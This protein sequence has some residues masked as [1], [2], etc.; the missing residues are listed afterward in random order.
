M[1][2]EKTFNL[3]KGQP[4]QIFG[5]SENGYTLKDRTEV[6]PKFLLTNPR[7]AVFVASLAEPSKE[8]LKDFLTL[9]ELEI[10]KKRDTYFH[11][12]HLERLPPF[13]QTIAGDFRHTPFIEQAN[14]FYVYSTKHV[15]LIVIEEQINPPINIKH[16]VGEYERVTYNL[17][18]V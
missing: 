14:A 1:R 16:R 15:N 10:I 12:T 9:A 13:E 6:N 4:V 5:D 11:Y 17:C 2:K 18:S 3:K 8:D 7:N